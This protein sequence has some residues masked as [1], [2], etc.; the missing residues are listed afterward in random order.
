MLEIGNKAP[1][2]KLENQDGKCIDLE[3]IDKN[4]VL[5][6]YPKDDTPGCTV[7]G[8]DFSELNNEFLKFDTIV[9]G[10][11][12]DSIESHRKFKEKKCFTIDLL[13]DTELLLSKSFG[14]WGEKS[15][16]GKKYQGMHRKTFFINK[17]KIVTQIWPKV[18]V[19]NHAKA[20]LEFVKENV[21]SSY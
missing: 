17:D 2:I 21:L 10:V 6:F 7:E 11:S 4:L 16:F 8:K 19:K 14:A 15:M 12:K 13:A 1:L 3:S 5:Y 18:S 20:V 9:Y